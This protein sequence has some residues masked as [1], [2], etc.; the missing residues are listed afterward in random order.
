MFQQYPGVVH[1]VEATQ[2][3]GQPSWGECNFIVLTSSTNVSIVD[4]PASA[5]VTPLLP[6]DVLQRT[7][8]NK[9]SVS[10]VSYRKPWIG[11]DYN[12]GDGEIVWKIS[13]QMQTICI[14]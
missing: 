10:K 1:R 3:R 2:R 13:F 7:K 12:N 11:G 4:L 14:T 8:N 9:D 6:S 5:E